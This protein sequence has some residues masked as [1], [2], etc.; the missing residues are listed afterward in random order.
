MDR[1]TIIDAYLQI[2]KIDNT[3]PDDVLDF[4]KEAA[5]S[6]LEEQETLPSEMG[7]YSVIINDGFCAWKFPV[8]TGDNK[9][10]IMDL[11]GV[12]FKAFDSPFDKG[13]L[14][15]DYLYIS[16]KIKS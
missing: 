8:K 16:P 1:K 14:V 7:E 13:K 3:I 11:I 10:C 12:L 5:L 6:K 15:G 2:R 9:T 4:M